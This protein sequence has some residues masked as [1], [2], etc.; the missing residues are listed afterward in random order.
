MTTAQPGTLVKLSWWRN[1]RSLNAQTPVRQLPCRSVRMMFMWQLSNL[2]NKVRNLGLTGSAPAAEDQPMVGILLLWNKYH[3]IKVCSSC[4]RSL[5][6]VYLVCLQFENLWSS[7]CSDGS[8]TK[9]SVKIP[10]A[11][12]QQQGLHGIWAPRS[13]DIANRR[14]SRALKFF[15]SSWLSRLH[16]LPAAAKIS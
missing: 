11:G 15:S 6:G 5:F 2:C 9:I 10:A 16:S 8:G 7:Y 13:I 4:G 14:H 3:T 12:A 1:C